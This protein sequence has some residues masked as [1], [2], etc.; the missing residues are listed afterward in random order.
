VIRGA[1]VR[2]WVWA[3]LLLFKTGQDRTGRA[4]HTNLE[5]IAMNTEA[6]KEPSPR[7]QVKTGLKGGRLAAN[8]NRQLKAARTA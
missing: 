5:E 1:R 4:A 8:H 3:R 2:R 6:K 7:L